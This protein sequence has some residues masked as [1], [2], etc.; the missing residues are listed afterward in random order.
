[1]SSFLTRHKTTVSKTSR[2][3]TPMQYKAA[4][5]L[6]ELALEKFRNFYHL[7]ALTQIQ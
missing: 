1:M 3:T 6:V 2:L 7:E 4:K 5:H